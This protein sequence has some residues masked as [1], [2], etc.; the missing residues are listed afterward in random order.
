MLLSK[1]T[2]ERLMLG[3]IIPSIHKA[4][5]QLLSALI[6]CTKKILVPFCG[7]I[8][9]QLTQT[10]SW[11]HVNC[12]TVGMDKPYSHLRET[13]YAVTCDLLKTLGGCC[14][15]GLLGSEFIQELLSDIRA[16]EIELKINSSKL[17]KNN[18]SDGP[19]SS[20][21]RK[22][23]G[24]Y[25]EISRGQGLAKK[26]NKTANH[27]TCS[28]ALEALRWLLHTNG[29]T[30]MTKTMKEIVHC[31]MEVSNRMQ[32]CADSPALPYA[33]PACRV[34]I[35]RAVLALVLVPHPTV[36]PPVHL[37]F[38]LLQGGLQTQTCRCHRAVEKL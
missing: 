1:R 3:Y 13:V 6:L 32:Q 25:Q 35:Y 28:M 15:L 19:S 36:P 22:K 33:H 18:S 14:D 30:V 11:T 29:S 10:L 37:A 17:N 27:S 20:K 34:G 24:G 31:L 4:A 5:L 16:E 12:Y 9:S 7:C 2:T 8:I 21:K 23:S 38:R 26:I